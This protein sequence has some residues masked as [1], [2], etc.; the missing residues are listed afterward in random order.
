MDE[1]SNINDC[2]RRREPRSDKNF[3]LQLSGSDVVAEAIDITTS[4]LSCLLNKRLPE[5]SEM[6][7]EF[8]LPESGDESSISCSGVVVRSMPARRESDRGR[9][10]FVTALYF[11]DID[12]TAKKRI[13]SFTEQ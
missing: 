2:E 12:D 9:E 3:S 4:G 13:S 8:L 5:L 10:R 6:K 1:N 7:V 11:L